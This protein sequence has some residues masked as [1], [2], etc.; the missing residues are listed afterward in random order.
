M[1]KDFTRKLVCEQEH[2]HGFSDDVLHQLSNN[3]SEPSLGTSY[4]SVSNH[5]A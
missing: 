5:N 1:N 4:L 2:I 3:A